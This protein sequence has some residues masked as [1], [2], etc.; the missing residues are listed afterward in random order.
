MAQLPY[1]AASFGANKPRNDDT[2]QRLLWK[3]AVLLSEGL[4]GGGVQ[5]VGVAGIYSTGPY[6][7]YHALT[8]TV[9]SS[10]TY[11][12]GST[13][14]AG[15]TLKAGDQIAGNIKSISI[16]SGTGELYKQI[17]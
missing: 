2:A 14:V 4:G 11:S 9:I 15:T 1:P 8:D 16:T 13:F 7:I 10:V 3:I 12:D 6:A 17:V 5:A